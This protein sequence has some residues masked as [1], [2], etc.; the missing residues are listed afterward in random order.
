[1]DIKDLLDLKINNFK[2][3]KRSEDCL[4]TCHPDLVLIHTVGLATCRVD[5]GI[6]EGARTIEL[7]REYFRDGKSRVNPDRYDSKTLVQKG[8]HLVNEYEPLSRATD[9]IAAVPGK[10]KLAFDEVHLSY[11]AGHL[12]AVSHMLY[13]MGH[14][15][16]LLR[17]GGNW[18]KDGNLITDQKLIDMPHVEL[19]LP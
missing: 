6:I 18:D 10:K 8:K 14:T 12:V 9:M 16:H 2:F 3:G 17:W 15:T 1:M 19:Y 4:A 5:Y 11:I 13:A 7:Q